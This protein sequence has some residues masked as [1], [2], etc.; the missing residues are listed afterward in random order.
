MG[1][2]TETVLRGALVMLPWI[3][4]FSAVY[5]TTN[6]KNSDIP[7]LSK[8]NSIILYVLGILLYI[9]GTIIN[10]AGVL[11]GILQDFRTIGIGHK[12]L[13]MLLVF[14]G[15]VGK[16]YKLVKVEG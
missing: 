12:I 1:I 3:I 11:D 4:S 15:H 5:L 6:R 14:Y 7:M 9:T 16:G 8:R 10:N 2:S 13:G